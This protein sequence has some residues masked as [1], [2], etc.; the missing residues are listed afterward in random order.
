MQETRKGQPTAAG[1]TRA[2]GEQGDRKKGRCGEAEGRGS[3]G[4]SVCV[5]ISMAA[6]RASGL[7]WD[8]LTFLRYLE[9]LGSPEL[10]VGLAGAGPVLVWYKESYVSN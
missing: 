7:R 2:G 3:S 8:H 10:S 9:N 1:F 6:A 4:R 5:A